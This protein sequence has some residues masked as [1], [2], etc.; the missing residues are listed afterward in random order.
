MY[1]RTAKGQT[2]TFAVSGKLWKRSLVMID[3]QTGTLW[4]HILGEAKR[5][6]LKGTELAAIPSVI[7]DWKSWRSKHPKTTVVMLRRTSRKFQ[8]DFYRDPRRFVMGYASGDKSRAWGFEHLQK[9]PVIND[10][11]AGRKLLVTFEASGSAPYLYDR[12]VGG[13]ALTFQFRRGRILD[14]KTG[15]L[16]DAET[17]RCVA[18]TMKGQQLTPLAGIISYRRAWRSFHPESTYWSPSKMGNR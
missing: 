16:W 15:S 6:K 12:R 3:T 18:G 13:T 14:A 2:L 1:D 5:G 7:T 9:R 17:G 10:A 4:S 11:F 8:R